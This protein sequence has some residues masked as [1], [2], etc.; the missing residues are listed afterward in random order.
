MSFDKKYSEIFKTYGIN[1]AGKMDVKEIVQKVEDLADDRVENLVGDEHVNRSEEEK[2]EMERKAQAALSDTSASDSEGITLYK[3]KKLQAFSYK[4]LYFHIQLWYDTKRAGLIYGD[5]GLGKSTIVRNVCEKIARSKGKIFINWSRCPVDV[6]KDAILNPSKYFALIDIRAS[7][8]EPTD[9]AGIPDISSVKDYL[10]TK[11]PKW[12]WFM[13]QDDADG[14]LFLDELNH[15]HRQVSNALHEVVLDR[16]AGGRKFSDNF[17]I[18]AAG[19][20]GSEWGNESIPKSLTNRF[21]G[22]VLIQDPVGWLKYAR[23]ANIDKRIIAF[24]ESNPEANFYRKP[25]EGEDDEQFA[26]P[27][28]FKYLSE[29]MA[30][31]FNKYDVGQS[32]GQRLP[33]NVIDIVGRIAA[34]ECG[35]E[36]AQEFVT[37]LKHMQSF[38]VHDIIK[39]APTFSNEKQKDKLHALMVY[40]AAQIKITIKSIKSHNNTA[41]KDENKVVEAV[42]S[43]LTH[44]PK[45]WKLACMHEIKRELGT[46]FVDFVN[47]LA[48]GNYDSKIKSDV[49]NTMPV[50]IGIM[51]KE[52]PSNTK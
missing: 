18:I 47:Y 23:K 21:A 41:T 49:H 28:Q 6:Q 36:W 19:N 44:L 52:E 27:R 16:G 2:E 46:S 25:A 43:M 13:S 7:G 8:M 30:H 26:T 35:G 15:G 4:T 5:P 37:Y 24:I 29:A 3:D 1:E 14:I 42:G 38:N 31:V 40:L 51:K 9:L 11:Q 17:G 33:D 39:T 50:I 34:T 20:I 22:G 48:D 12:V 10:E 45:D 32:T